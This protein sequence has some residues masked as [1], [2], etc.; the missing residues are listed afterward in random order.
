MGAMAA[1]GG[2]RRR[3]RRGWDIVAMMMYEG[4]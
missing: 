3:M 4:L 1:S 2:E